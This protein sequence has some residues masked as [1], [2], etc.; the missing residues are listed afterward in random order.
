MPF[1]GN[2][3]APPNVYT[4]T[5]YENPIAATLEAL[6]IPVFIGEGNELL[7]QDNLEV[8]RGSSSSIDQQV[9]QEDQ[10]G[11]SVVSISDTGVVTLGA[12][13]GT[14]TRFQVRN[15]P[16]VSGDGNGRTTNDRSAVTVTIN[17]QPTVVMSL[18]GTKGIITL[19]EAPLPTD[20]VRCTYFFNRT[21]TYITDNV[22]GQVTQDGATVRGRTG[23]SSGGTF[24]F[25]STN[26][27]LKVFVPP[28]AGER[29][30]T[31][32]L[33]AGNVAS[34]TPS[35]LVVTINA[36][37]IG[38]LRASTYITNQ[39]TTAIALTASNNVTVGSGSANAVLGL[40]SGE[41]SGRNATFYTFQGPIVDGS[42]GGV[43]TTDP[44]DVT[45]RINN[46]Q[47]IPLSVDG[48]TRKVTLPYAPAVGDTVTIAYFFNTWQDTFD[49]LANIG[50]TEVT[51][52]G[53]TPDRN[54]YIDGADFILKD[55]KILWGTASL[56]S[57]GTTTAGKDIF[58]STQVSTT[59]VDNRVFLA[60]CAPVVDTSVVPS[61]ESSTQF[62]LNH[63]PTTG[64]GR[65]TPIGQ[66]LFQTVT[67]NRIDLP[68]NRPDLVLAY[69][70]YS[71]QDALDRGAVTVVRVDSDTS[72]IT[73]QS[74]VPKGAT[75]YATYYYNR[76]VDEE[77]T[78]TCQ[79]DGVSGIG[80][81]TVKDQG[82]ND[83][84]N[85]QYQQGSKN[86]ILTGITIE[87]PSGSEL[88][89]D[90]HLEGGSGTSF[91]G[92][93]EETVT[94]T[95]ATTEDSPAKH[96]VAG[97]DPYYPINNAS[98][99]ARI[100]IDNADLVTGANG[101]DLGDPTSIDAGFFASLLGDEIEYDASTGAT[102][103][104]L[105]I[106]NNEV[107]LVVD[108]IQISATV[109]VGAGKTAA[110]FV[111]AINTAAKAG[112]AVAPQY[113]A[114]T[115][116]DGPVITT[117]NEY[118]Q[119]SLHYTGDV[120]GAS[121][122]QTLTI[123]PNP[124]GYT[125]PA[126]LALELNTQLALLAGLN[127]TVTCA[128]DASGRMVFTLT[129][130]GA[131][132]AGYLEFVANAAPARDF[133]ILSGID[134]G[135]AA[136]NGQVK[137]LD[138]DIA[139]RYTV[140]AGALQ[141]DR[142]ILR[143]RIIPGGTGS[144]APE[145]A[146]GQAE[147]RVQ[148]TNDKAG[149]VNDTIGIAGW[150]ASVDPATMTGRLG[151]SG[152]QMT[153][154]A[155]ASDSQPRKMFYDGT[156]T[157]A[158]NDIFK[159]TLD[160]QPVVVDL[161][162][163]AAGTYRALGPETVANT[164]IRLIQD[165]LAALPGQP[166]GNLAAVQ[167]AG[168][169]RQE[170]ASIRITSTRNDETSEVLI[171]D[172]NA[173]SILGFSDGR[174][175]LRTSVQAAE[176]ASALMCHAQAAGA[177]TTMM[178]TYATPAATYFAAEGL[179][180]IYTDGANND[181]LYLQS[182]SVGTG[183]IVEWAAA[184]TEDVLRWGVGLGDSV[185]D[186]NVG[187]VG[188]SGYYVTSTD[189]A[190][191]GSINTSVFNA[192]VGQDGI[193]GQTYA[194]DVTGLRFTILSRPGSLGYPDTGSFRINVSKTL[195]TDSNIPVLAIPGVELLVTDTYNVGVGDTAIVETFE[196]GGQE[197]TV[198][199]LY[200]TSYIYAKQDF[201]TSLWTKLA[202]IEQTFG[203]VSLE[204]P[205]SLASY[206]AI[207]NGAVLVGIKQVLK[208]P[209]TQ[210]ASI[211]SYRDAIDDL[212]QP[213]P[214]G[215]TPDIIEMLRGDSTDLFLY[216]TRHADIMSSIRYRAERTIMAGVAGGTDPKEAQNVATTVG[217]TRFRMVYPDVATMNLTNNLN[218]TREILVD[219]PYLMAALVGSVVSPNVDV[220][221]P[222]TNRNLVGF[223][224]LARQLDMVE[225]NQVAVAGITV[226]QDL[227][228]FI[229]VRHGLT[230]NM[231]NVLTK[232][233]TV[234]LIADEV[235]RQSRNALARFIGI[236]FLPG[237]I[238]QIEGTLGKI[239][240]VLQ[241]EQIISAFTGVNAAIPTDDPTSV[242]MEAYYA[243]VFP[244]LYILLTYHLRSSLQ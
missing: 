238:T 203:E 176:I 187:E 130:A 98:D 117:V 188:I 37:N 42:N 66:S 36:A 43:T 87:F 107:N 68:T 150:R 141:Y 75:V 56:T 111:T 110:D 93:V 67:N 128:A 63:Q 94:V 152:G 136:N 205:V 219:G 157:Q 108:G 148:G 195:T 220:A 32:P 159:F 217:A 12:F 207:L 95:F 88:T 194:D 166:F 183:S 59:L 46:T 116:F 167:S 153:G 181:Y 122:V 173:N 100:K 137:I 10:T 174:R 178:L 92:P 233:P 60:S 237:V 57:A 97:A 9:V 142:I 4:Q 35:Q 73:L 102:S 158:A 74:P 184:T 196:R 71:V 14:L 218:Q 179:A 61:V 198:G 99:K 230:T 138:G 169:I 123:T 45:V 239:L 156:G 54:D 50:V 70:G 48:Q 49:Y 186:G 83:I 224:Q 55:D 106:T 7:F 177:F 127:A 112:G 229:N 27:L 38:S 212:V 78:L 124:T 202:A 109:A 210:S 146:I 39:G 213:L 193:V 81:Y 5:L 19:V 30:I 170:G 168:I 114:S 121:G 16:I 13:D 2:N 79:L 89:S 29:T 52:C 190:G 26:N 189:P 6:K 222:W 135:A 209:G 15:F 69:W 164:V 64:N 143:N 204:N 201:S 163:A 126:A 84:Y 11:R 225:Q 51:R 200:Y 134:T 147:L 228:P 47:V 244:L 103:Y 22:S 58:G 33:G 90:V 171:G 86:A 31:I 133:A 85:A 25:N 191:S 101:V 21:D 192:G 1:P 72:T 62:Q 236:K 154:A 34:Y 227:T 185:G 18:D 96:T 182:Q 145:H 8:V 119:L 161:Q 240:S 197:P 221:T 232:T 208:E 105:D 139:R 215:I 151:W 118:D 3:Y 243:P 231:T 223:N 132:A 216:A 115:I 40:V 131:D 144:M 113:Q 125:T 175:A 24:D 165:A 162:G 23:V 214:G 180:G 241:E 65:S 82:A 44:A 77:Y 20:L 28:L 234:A 120:S 155:N 242:I 129:R 41:T 53:I 211:T 160:T 17:G 226:L 91:T 104:T 140:G 149:L 206:L 76:L 199:D 80:T 235:Q 172:G